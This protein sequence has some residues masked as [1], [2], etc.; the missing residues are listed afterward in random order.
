[1]ISETYIW[2]LEQLP[3]IRYVISLSS[4]ASSAVAAE[5]AIERYGHSRVELVFCDTRK[6]DDDNY[7]FL[8]DCQKRWNMPITWLTD[9]REPLS[10]AEQE[11]IIP[12]QKI[13]PCTKA[14]KIVPMQNYIKELEQDG[15]R[16]VMLIGMNARDKARGRLG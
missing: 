16:V 8:V 1:M 9:G 12:N 2:T 11:H 3:P 7:R 15:S 13:A 14:L 10:V 6:E 5:R 4:G